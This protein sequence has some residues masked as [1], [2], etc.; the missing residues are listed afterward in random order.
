MYAL[1]LWAYVSHG[2]YV[3]E[4]HLKESVFFF[5]YAGPGNPKVMRLEKRHSNTADH[6]VYSQD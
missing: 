1:Y 3:I 2:A 6:L 4:A 5:H